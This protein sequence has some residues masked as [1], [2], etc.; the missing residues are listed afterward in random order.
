MGTG[1]KI[2]RLIITGLSGD[3]GKTV[4]SLSILAALKKRGIK[5]SP[6]KKG[7]DYIDA[8]CLGSLAGRD[9][10]NLDTWLTGPDDVLDIFTSA[11]AGADLALVEGNRGLFDGKDVEGSHST[12]E[13]AKILQA[14]LI[15]VVDATKATRTVAAL[16][17]GCQSFDPEVQLAGVILNKIAGARHQRTITDSIERYCSLPV[18]GTIPKLGDDARIIPGRH[19]GL[20]PP[21]E[22]AIEH[23]FIKKLTSIAENYIN[24][25]QL[26]D[27]ATQAAPLDGVA[28]HHHEKSEADVKIGYFK[29]SVFTFYYPD[30]L[31][32][33]QRSGARLVPI[34]SL[35]DRDLPEIDSLYIGGGF[36]ETQ[37]ERLTENRSLMT[38]VKKGADS[39]LPIYAECGGLIYLC[40]S[41]NWEG[42][43]YPMAGVFPLDL[44]MHKKPAGHG[45]TLLEIDRPNPY[46]KVGMDIRGHEFHYSSPVT[47]LVPE[48]CCLVKAGVGI[49]KKRDGLIYNNV[50]AMYT[51]IHAAGTR[52]WAEALVGNARQY[53]RGRESRPENTANLRDAVAGATM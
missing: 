52:E 36:P 2:A 45:Y 39:G 23:N 15:L 49:G 5:V 9:C 29:D 32:A 12:A 50:L 51:H 53:L 17:K 16:V 10:R 20:V 19:L 47:D 37:A 30:N 46:F 25:D 48:S 3:S 22:Y 13:L 44:V 27:I 42:K 1:V 11:A 31:E 8:A 38:A 41:L 18:L 28:R 34:D 35:T 33:L 26:I 14:P 6:F 24:I 43:N 40:Q 7:P 21:A 4:V